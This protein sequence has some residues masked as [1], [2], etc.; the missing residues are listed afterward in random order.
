MIK[1]NRMDED[2]TFSLNVTL[3]VKKNRLEVIL[4]QHHEKLILLT[5]CDRSIESLIKKGLQ[6]SD[7]R[8][9]VFD[10]EVVEIHQMKP[11]ERPRGAYQLMEYRVTLKVQTVINHGVSQ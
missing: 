1:L 8:V 2:R 9:F 5:L 4:P 6:R 3:Q 11:V 7:L 10:K